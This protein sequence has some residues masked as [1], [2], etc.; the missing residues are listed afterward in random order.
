MAL[1]VHWRYIAPQIFILCNKHG[2][3]PSKIEMKSGMILQTA[4]FTLQVKIRSN[5]MSV[6][7]KDC[8]ELMRH[9]THVSYICLYLGKL[10]DCN[11]W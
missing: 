5:L 9:Y 4:S 11:Q 3:V 2:K 7:G 10:L 6:Y 8:K 1:S